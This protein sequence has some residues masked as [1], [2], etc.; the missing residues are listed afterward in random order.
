MTSGIAFPF[1][2]LAEDTVTLDGLL[3]GHSGQPLFPFLPML[4]NWDYAADIDLRISISIDMERAARDLSIPK[5][6]LR[7][8][9]V[10]KIGTGRGRFP[11]RVERAMS[12]VFAQDTNGSLELHTRVPGNALSGR[13]VVRAEVLLDTIAEN[14]SLL[15]PAKAGS[16]LWSQEFV[17]DL[18]D[19]GD[20][21]FPIELVS[22]G[23]TFPNQKHVNSPWYLSWRTNALTADF[24]GTVRL[25]V[26]SDNEELADRVIAGDAL[27]LQ[28]IVGDV[29]L[30]MVG[31]VIDAEDLDD[32]LADCEEGSV[33]AQIFGWMKLAFPNRSISEVRRIKRNAPGM[34]HSSV[35]AAAE[36]KDDE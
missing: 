26:N 12:L 23:Q 30:Q 22:F 36:L 2:T 11:R 18:E 24:S 25:Y 32:Q 20:N 17:V 33:G 4:P 6:E 14:A 19:G 21:R 34:F 16:R 9:V 29:M 35:H 5:D 8:A 10:L 3:I 13:M 27:T 7:L 28:A 31:S 1:L 15:S